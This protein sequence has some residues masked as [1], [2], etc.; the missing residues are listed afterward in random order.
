[1]TMVERKGRPIASSSNDL[2]AT[3]RQMSAEQ[4]FPFR[5]QFLPAV[6]PP[7]A[8]PAR[9]LTLWA[10]YSLE[11]LIVA[12][13]LIPHDLGFFMFAFGDRGSW[14]VVQY[15]TAHGLRPTIDFGYPY[16]LLPLI[17]GRI[18]F[19]IFGLTPAAFK[20]AMVAG[21]IAMAGGMAR[22]A[23]A[24]RLSRIG[25]AL[26]VIALPVAIQ[27]SLPSLAHML[28]AVLLCLALGEHSRGNRG[29]ALALVTAA[30]FAKPALGYSYGLLLLALILAAC[31]RQGSVNSRSKASG[32][33]ND[34]NGA[35]A[36]GASKMDWRALG[37]ILMP[38]AVTG[39]LLLVVLAS[40]YGL[41]PL[42]S[43]VLPSNG[44]RI[45][46]AQHFGFFTPWSRTFW[47]P[48]AGGLRDYMLTVAPFWIGST[49][50][51]ALAGLAAGWRLLTTFS[52]GHQWRLPRH[53]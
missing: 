49:V 9:F 34:G 24:M 2:P 4:S 47:Y 50:W 42:L 36:D 30:C 22:F 45:Y 25:Q 1:M 7:A 13:L 37:Y 46:R 43:S 11:V 35:N 3:P 5:G 39:T 14:L 15:L 8:E 40:V 41:R 51:L 10:A 27:S 17:V 6:A 26:V 29:V 38:A 33:S 19:G 48:T 16:G 23:S 52:K 53:T 20:L 44:I 21:G 12:F 18:W 28:E 32:Q 31:R